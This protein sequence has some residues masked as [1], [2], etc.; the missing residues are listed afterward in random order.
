MRNYYNTVHKMYVTLSVYLGRWDNMIVGYA[1]CAG[2][3]G[4]DGI[5]QVGFL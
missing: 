1:G 4:K 2:L 5:L 3:L